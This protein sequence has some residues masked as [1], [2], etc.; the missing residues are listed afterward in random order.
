MSIEDAQ[1][2]CIG[3]ASSMAENV[4]RHVSLFHR[5]WLPF[6]LQITYVFVFIT[7]YVF[8]VSVLGFGRRREAANLLV[9]YV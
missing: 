7:F 1:Q 8:V 9:V 2:I 3:G 4:M 5:D 6:R